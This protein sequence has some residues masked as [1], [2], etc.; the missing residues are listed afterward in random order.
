M[1]IK[2]KAHEKLSFDNIERV[3]QQLEEDNPITKKEACDML[4]IR[5][6]TTRLQR[7]IE[8]HQDL[9][10]FRETRKAQNK[11][12]MATQ[13][14]IRSVVKMYLDGDNFSSIANSLYRSPA[15][16]KNIVERVGIPQK[17]ADSDY[18][19]MKKAMLPEQCVA[20][21]FE[22]NEKVWYPKKNRFALIKDEITQKY[23]SERRGYACYGNITQ[24]VNYEDKW[25]SKCYKI[26]ILEPCDTSQTLFPWVDGEKTGYWGS[27]LTHDLGS[28]RHLQEYL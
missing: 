14:E 19:G 2:S 13:D 18:E 9:K 3:I 5:Y 15:F 20:L 26:F 16:V 23:Q 21:E 10:Q 11:G 27:A 25:G 1:A 12:K 8:D 22:Y 17:L 28:L 7:I 6:N 24:C 4:N